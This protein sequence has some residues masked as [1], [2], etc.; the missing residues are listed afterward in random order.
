MPR[1][2]RK[3]L[4]ASARS[5][6]ESASVPSRSN[7]TTDTDSGRAAAKPSGMRLAECREVVD[8]DV[9]L[10]AVGPGQ[11]VVRHSGECREV[12]PG[13]PRVAGKLGGTNELAPIVRAPRQHAQHI[14][15]AE[16]CI[17]VRLRI[18]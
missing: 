2:W 6:A 18:A 1:A 8:R 10:D 3:R 5:P 12:E 11:R 9:V 4:S 13:T 17:G 14:L 7:S 16:N 15:G